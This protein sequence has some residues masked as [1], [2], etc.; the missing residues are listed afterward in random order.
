ME[1]WNLALSFWQNYKE[2]CKCA[3]ARDSYDYGF[4][5]VFAVFEL[6]ISTYLH[7][8]DVDGGDL[9]GKRCGEKEE[10]LLYH[11]YFLISGGPD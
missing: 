3:D 7:S 8:V 5:C 10:K 11:N 2:I 4:L 6:C 9:W 1:F